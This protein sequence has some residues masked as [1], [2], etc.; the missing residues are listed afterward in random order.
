MNLDYCKILFFIFFPHFSSSICIN[1]FVLWRISIRWGFA[2]EI[3]SRR[4]YSS[5]QIP[6]FWNCA[7]L[8][9]PSIWLRASLMC[10][11]SAVATTAHLSSFLVLSITL[12]RSVNSKFKL[13]FIIFIEMCKVFILKK[14]WYSYN[15]KELLCVIL[16]E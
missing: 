5:I 3:S 16:W 2:I 4:I 1:C 13:T 9:R 14:H 10:L 11:T 6:A 12:Q 15:R 7:T 8:A